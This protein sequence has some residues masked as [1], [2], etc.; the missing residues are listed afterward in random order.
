MGTERAY[1]NAPVPVLDPD[2]AGGVRLAST[3]LH[4]GP[5]D[6]IEAL[7]GVLDEVTGQL[8]S[9][10]EMGEMES[11]R[12]QMAMDRQSKLM[13]M[14]SNILKTISDTTSTLAQNLK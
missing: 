5:I 10:S 4:P 3:D 9:M 14:L 2:A 1:H 6:G 7:R 12:M 13:T 8:D 11:L